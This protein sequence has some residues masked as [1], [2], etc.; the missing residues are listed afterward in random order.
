MSFSAEDARAAAVN[1]D[2]LGEP[3][4]FH[5]HTGTVRAI[6]A[7]VE[8]NIRIYTSAVDSGGVSE[9]R[10]LVAFL[11]SDAPDWRRDDRVVDKEGRSYLLKDET[12]ESDDLVVEVTAL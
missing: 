4:V 10:N 2:L 11:Y 7:Q 8:R 3:V 5:S 9:F 1:I 12:D 6:K